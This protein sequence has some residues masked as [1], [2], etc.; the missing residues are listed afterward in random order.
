[1][2]GKTNASL[3]VVLEFLNQLEEQ[4]ISYRLEHNR[5][6]TVMVLIAVPGQRWEVEFFEDGQIE[7]E[8]FTS[9]GEIQGE[10]ILEELFREFGDPKH[11]IPLAVRDQVK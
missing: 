3:G 2:S 9:S 4:Q 10:E 1:M 5:A 11:S 7:I 6:E 8:R